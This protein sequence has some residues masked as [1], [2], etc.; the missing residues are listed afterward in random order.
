MA[1][2]VREP[3]KNLVTDFPISGGGTQDQFSLPPVGGLYV[4]GGRGRTRTFYFY[5][6]FFFFFNMQDL[7]A[8]LERD[9]ESDRLG[10]P[11]ASHDPMKIYRVYWYLHAQKYTL[12]VDLHV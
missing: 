8:Q 11:G 2:E 5:F 9:P 7:R 12:F 3:P 1:S 6:N 4:F 10:H